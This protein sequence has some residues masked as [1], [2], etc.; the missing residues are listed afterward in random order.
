M[1]YSYHEEKLPFKYLEP[2]LMP[3]MVWTIRQRKIIHL[4]SSSLKSW[5][6][7]F[8]SEKEALKFFN[9]SIMSPRVL[10]L[11]VTRSWF[12]KILKGHKK[13]DFRE[14]KPYWIKR[15]KGDFDWV[16]IVNGYGKNR[17]TLLADFRGVRITDDDELTDLG[18]GS[19]F[20][21]G[22]GVVWD[23]RNV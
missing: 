5:E 14:I 1:L 8:D 4:H 11:V 22:V 23:W 3:S 7:V 6:Y 19:F 9:K 12:D 17:P 10:R 21:I 2:W 18:T 20:A 16:E 15:L 13:E